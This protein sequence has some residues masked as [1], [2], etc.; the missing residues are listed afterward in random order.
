MALVSEYLYRTEGKLHMK[1]N[2]TH[3]MT[4]KKVFT[5]GDMFCAFIPSVPICNNKLPN[6]TFCIK[7]EQLCIYVK[8]TKQRRE[9]R[10]ANNSGRHLESEAA[11]KFPTV[12]LDP[13]NKSL[14]GQGLCLCYLMTP[15]L[16]YDHNFLNLQITRSDIRPRIKWAVSLV[17]AY[18]HFNLPQG[19]VWVCMGWHTHCTRVWYVVRRQLSWVSPKGG[20]EC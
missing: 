17:I 7:C 12:V 10:E 1:G 5:I 19:I 11:K 14:C 2:A 13:E 18:G 6:V 20:G 9:I 15:G 4:R 16:M 3:G 8:K